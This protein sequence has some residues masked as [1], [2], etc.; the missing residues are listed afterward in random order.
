MILTDAMSTGTT[1][2]AGARMT[3][4]LKDFVTEGVKIGDTIRNVTDGSSAT[5]TAL[6]ATTITGVLAGG[7]E[8]DWNVGDLYAI[9]LERVGTIVFKVALSPGA[10]AMNLAPRTT[11]HSFSDENNHVNTTYGP[12]S[13]ARWLIHRS[14]TIPG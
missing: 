9:D 3:D 11:L 7:T 13:P 4:V 1:T 14:G 2:L 8:N 6:T 5:I 12:P 10:E